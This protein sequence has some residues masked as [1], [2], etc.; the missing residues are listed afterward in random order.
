MM[1]E[2]DICNQALARI[3]SKRINAMTDS[4][5]EAIRCTT[6]YAQDRDATLQGHSWRFAIQRALLS[7]DA[8]TPLFGYDHQYILPS[9]CLRVLH[10]PREQ[11]QVEGQRLLTD[12]DDCHIKYIRRVEDVS[13][14]TPMFVKLL[15]AMLAVDLSGPL[16]QDKNLR[17]QLQGEVGSIRSD[18]RLLDEIESGLG[19]RHPISWREARYFNVARGG[20]RA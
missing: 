12:D 8:T 7:E 20:R 4:T 9:D 14:F 11:F 3:G 1:T 19:D 15:A 10:G 2:T 17:Q 5:V 6:F 16:T 13:Q 18:A